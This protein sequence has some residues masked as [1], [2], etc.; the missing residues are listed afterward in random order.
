[1]VVAL[2]VKAL[3]DGKETAQA[4]RGPPISGL[5]Q[6][7]DVPQVFGPPVA[8]DEVAE[9]TEVAANRARE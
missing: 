4:G 8:G 2:E 5:P 1:M 7:A 9:Q 6:L 3:S